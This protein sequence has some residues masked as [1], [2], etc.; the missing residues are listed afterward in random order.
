V[1]VRLLR[2]DQEQGLRN[3]VKVRANLH[4]I[5]RWVVDRLHNRVAPELRKVVV[6][7]LFHNHALVV[8]HHRQ[9]SSSS[10][11]H[12][13]LHQAHNSNSIP[14][15]ARL[16]RVIKPTG[17]TGTV[18]ARRNNNNNNSSPLSDASL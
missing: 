4:K 7:V 11:K 5:G 14:R 3:K 1:P 9:A 10:N 16:P 15:T 18:T 12:A 8:R 2:H 17:R 6:V 13:H